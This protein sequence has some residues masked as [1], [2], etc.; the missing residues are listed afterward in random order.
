PP[1]SAIALRSHRRIRV[2]ARWPASAGS[3]RSGC[4]R[5]RRPV[6]AKA[7]H[8][9]SWRPVYFRA[10]PDVLTQVPGPAKPG[11]VRAMRHL[12][13]LIA[14]ILIAPVAWVL[15]ALGQ[16]KTASTVTPW[17]GGGAFNTADLIVP[18]A[19]AVAAGALIGLIGTLRISPIGALIVGVVYVALF[20]ALFITPQSTLNAV[21]HNL[22]GLGQSVDLRVPIIN[23]TLLIVGIL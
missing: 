1:T 10:C 9:R 3:R 21:P 15:I 2:R 18:V 8:L 13:S 14:G 6:A 7:P 12:G 19:F 22:R 23:G 5:A 4:G 11:T 16:Q 20:V 17:L